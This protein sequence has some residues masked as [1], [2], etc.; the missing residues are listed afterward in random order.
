MNSIFHL[1]YLEMLYFTSHY[2][3]ERIL[4]VPWIFLF[5]WNSPEYFLI[6]EWA[7]ETGTAGNPTGEAEGTDTAAQNP[8]RWLGNICLSRGQLWLPATVCGLGKTAGEKHQGRVH[9]Y[10]KLPCTFQHSQYFVNLSCSSVAL[11]RIPLLAQLKGNFCC[12]MGPV[13]IHTWKHQ[14]QSFYN[15]FIELSCFSGHY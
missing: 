15:R 14:S 3:V 8:A 13:F 10:L 2:W 7:G 4:N 11:L 12:Y 5:L 6:L 1:D 9:H